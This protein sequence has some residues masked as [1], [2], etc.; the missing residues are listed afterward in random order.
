MKREDYIAYH[1]R[2]TER[3]IAI[4]RA[5]N[6][7]YSG[8]NDDPFFNFTRVEALGVCDT[9]I[10]FIT[11]MTDKLSRIVTFVRTGTL[12]VSEESVED[13]LL[14]LANYCILLAG[15]IRAKRARHEGANGAIRAASS[16]GR[17]RGA[18]L[19]HQRRSGRHNARSL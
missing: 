1:R 19:A 10:G 14:D 8:G 9:E 6:E 11:R 17:V 15:Y 4:T 7:D 5:K 16:R 3:M 2:C 18:R 12:Q 13:T